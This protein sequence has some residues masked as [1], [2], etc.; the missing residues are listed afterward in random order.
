MVFEHNALDN[1]KQITY[2]TISTLRSPR[3]TMLCR[4]L[5]ITDIPEQGP[6]G[7]VPNTRQTEHNTSEHRIPY[8]VEY[9]LPTIGTINRQAMGYWE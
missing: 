7:V 4:G 1:T 2:E 3:S 6:C 8:S 5:D 9:T